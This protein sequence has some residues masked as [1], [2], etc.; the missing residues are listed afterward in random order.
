MKLIDLPNY[1][2]LVSRYHLL[3]RAARHDSGTHERLIEFCYVL[4]VILGV[5]T[6]EVKRQ[7]DN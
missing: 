5:S 2:E 6:D 7:L 4:A 3:S 1:P